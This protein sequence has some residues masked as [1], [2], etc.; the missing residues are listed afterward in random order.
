MDVRTS[1][2][3]NIGATNVAR[4]AGKKL[5]VLTLALDALKGLLPTLGMIALADALAPQEAQV[6]WVGA[7]GLAA[8]LG[9]CYSLWLGFRGGKGVATAFGVLLAFAPFAALVGFVLYVA[10]YATLRISS[11]GSLLAAV[12]VPAL[13]FVT[14]PPALGYYVLVMVA[15]IVWKHRGNI[16]RLLSRS[17]GKV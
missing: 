3:G 7:A 14:E 6:L 13:V 5:G 15:V 8:F 4:V 10:V 11:V 9:H 1:G 17:E 2:S 12:A 16:Q